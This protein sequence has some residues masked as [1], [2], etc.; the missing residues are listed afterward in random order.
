MSNCFA[1]SSLRSRMPLD[2]ER[3]KIQ[4]M[5][6]R[7][8]LILACLTPLNHHCLWPR[9]YSLWHA[10]HQSQFTGAESI[11]AIH[12]LPEVCKGWEVIVMYPSSQP[13]Q[14]NSDN[15]LKLTRYNFVSLMFY[16]KQLD[17]LAA[18]SLFADA[19]TFVSDGVSPRTGTLWPEANCAAAYAKIAKAS[20]YA[21][22]QSKLTKAVT[23]FL[24]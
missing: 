13:T 5:Q 4:D 2:T 10:D 17:P 21:S 8:S 11:G 15:E 7:D 16:H 19:N 18:G 14:T 23:V 24:Y 3:W 9:L 1:Y 12:I 6:V 22:G 20:T